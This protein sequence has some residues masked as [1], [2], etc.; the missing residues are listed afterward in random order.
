[1]KFASTEKLN[2][3][4]ELE[5]E[6]FEVLGISGNESS[7]CRLRGKLVKGFVKSHEMVDEVIEKLIV[8]FNIN[9]IEKEGCIY[10]VNLFLSKTQ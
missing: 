6:Y 3:M 7:R 9:I 2:E 10:N 4:K 8:S 1:M 5:N